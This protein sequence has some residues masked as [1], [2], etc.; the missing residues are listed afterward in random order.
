MRR[1]NDLVRSV[2]LSLRCQRRRKHVKQRVK[3][4]V[5]LPQL[6]NLF[7]RVQN[8]RMV[9]TIIETA[10]FRQAP[11]GDMLCQ[12]HRY[13]SAQARRC[14]VTSDAAGSEVR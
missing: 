4:L 3:R 7:D 14:G 1:G 12:I 13:L 5:R 6:L 10:D 11:A 9:T 2:P 8:G